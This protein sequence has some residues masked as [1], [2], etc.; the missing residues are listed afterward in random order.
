MVRA[1]SGILIWG[2][3]LAAGGVAIGSTWERA[4]A[5]KAL[6]QSYTEQIN[7]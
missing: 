2:L 7:E 5:D 3:V 1:A 4:E 6:I